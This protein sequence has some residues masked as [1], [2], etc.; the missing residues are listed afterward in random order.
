[1]SVYHSN[2]FNRRK[3]SRILAFFVKVY[4]AKIFKMAIR[5]SLSSEIFLQQ[6]FAKVYPVKFIKS[7]SIY[8]YLFVKH[9]KSQLKDVFFPFSLILIKNFR[10]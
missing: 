3:L 10:N 6:Q 1:M 8:F 2:Y 9:K 5:E 4:L 7:F